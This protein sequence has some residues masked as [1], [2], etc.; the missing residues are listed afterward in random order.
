MQDSRKFLSKRQFEKFRVNFQRL[1]LSKT[2]VAKRE[3]L[4]TR[5]GKFW[6]N[7]K[8]FFLKCALGNFNQ[9]PKTTKFTTRK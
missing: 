7:I 9:N 1:F 5:L 2:M 4:F 6:Q 3:A 8:P